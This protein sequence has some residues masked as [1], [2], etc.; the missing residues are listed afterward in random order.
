MWDAI[1]KCDAIV[2]DY[3]QRLD[4]V[5]VY[6]KNLPFLCTQQYLGQRTLWVALAILGIALV[7]VTWALVWMD[8]TNQRTER[9]RQL[10]HPSV[11]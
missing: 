3:V 9:D 2:G 8:V 5:L 10:G 1:A 7:G 11:R 4:P 6:A